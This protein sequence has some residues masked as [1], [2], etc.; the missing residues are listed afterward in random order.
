LI[1]G[2][3]RSQQVDN[4]ALLDYYR[5]SVD[6]DLMD[7]CATIA[8][9]IAKKSNKV[10]PTGALCAHLYMFYKKDRRKADVFADDLL[11][12]VRG[13]RKLMAKIRVVKQQSGGR[14][15]EV[16]YNQLLI[17]AWNCYRAGKTVTAAALNW[18]DGKDFV[19]IA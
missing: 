7:D 10:L 3:D 12:G 18:I 16:F 5:E 6:R 13:G 19:Q 1:I 4:Q 17:Q 8:K 15:N 11:K 14:L 9:K 2:T